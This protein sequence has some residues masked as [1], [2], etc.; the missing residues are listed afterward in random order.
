MSE[1][2][3]SSTHTGVE[4]VSSTT[5]P[6]APDE[7]QVN[8]VEVNTCSVNVLVNGVGPVGVFEVNGTT[9]RQNAQAITEV[10]GQNP[11]GMLG[12]PIQG[13]RAGNT[14]YQNLT[15]YP[16]L[17]MAS[18]LPSSNNTAIFTGQVGSTPSLGTTVCCASTRVA[19]TRAET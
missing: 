3:L 15:G 14:V 19:A 18:F 11:F 16:I 12:T 7:I 8:S 9:V 2:V 10:F 4:W 17:V 1:Y 5:L 13:L 6:P